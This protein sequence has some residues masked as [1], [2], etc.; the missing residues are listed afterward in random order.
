[1]TGHGIMARGPCSAYGP[2]GWDI[3][4]IAMRAVQHYLFLARMRAKSI[5]IMSTKEE[6]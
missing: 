4:S 3:T 1:M 6:L 5:F 2:H